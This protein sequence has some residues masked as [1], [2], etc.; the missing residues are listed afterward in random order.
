MCVL[1]FQVSNADEESAFADALNKFAEHLN[2]EKM[3][4]DD[5]RQPA[6]PP[7]SFT[8]RRKFPAISVAS[9]EESKTADESLPAAGAKAAAVAAAPTNARRILFSQFSSR[10]ERKVAEPV[11]TER[12]GGPGCSEREGDGKLSR[13]SSGG[14]AKPTAVVVAPADSAVPR[15]D[16]PMVAR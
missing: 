15:D 8:F 2:S 3:P 7:V 10:G 4:L 12:R 1:L 11:E 16:G 14:E 9:D 5:P 6:S 13:G